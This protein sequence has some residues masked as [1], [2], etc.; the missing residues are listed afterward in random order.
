MVFEL[1]QGEVFLLG[2]SS[3]RAEKITHDRVLVTPAAG[4]PG[5]MPFWHGDRP[6][7]RASVRDAHRRAGARH[8][9]GTRGRRA[10]SADDHALAAGAPPK[11]SPPTC[12][13]RSRRRARCPS[14]RAIVVERFVD[15]I[16]DWRV[17]VL[18]PF[19]SRVI[20]P[21]AI[22]VAA[23]LREKY[24]DADVHY[25]DDGMAF[26]VPAC[27][28]PPPTELLL[29]SAD[30]IETH[31][32]ARPRGLGALRGALPRVRR[33]GRCSC[34][35]ATRDGAPRSGR[36]E[37]APRPCSRSRRATRTFPSSSRR[38]ASACATCSICRASSTLL[39][40]V[41]A[42]RVRVTTVDTRAPSPFAASVL[43]AFVANFIYE[44]D[45][46][47]AERRAQAMAIDF[48]R[49]R[50]LLGEAEIRQ[51]LDAER[52]RGARA[53]APAPLAA[54][55][56]RRRR[57]RHAPGRRRPLAR[58]APCA[59]L[60]VRPRPS[61][62]RGSSSRP[63]APCPSASAD[64][65][66]SSAA[67]DAA[68][69]RDAL[70]LDAARR[71]AAGA[72]RGRP[73]TR[74]AISWRATRARTDPSS[75][76]TSR[77]AS[78][79]IPAA[80]SAPIAELVAE[81]RLVEG[82]FLPGGTKRELCDR[83]VLE[84][85]RR[86]SL[87]KLRR[88][89]EPV[90]AR[91]LWRDSCS[92]GK[93]YRGRVA[94]AT[95]CSRS[96]ASSRAVPSWHRRW[97]PQ[98]C[99]RA[100]TR[101]A[102]GIS[103]RSARPAR[104]A[105]RASSRSARATGGSRSTART[106]RRCSIEPCA[107]VDGPL[108]AARARTARAP[109]GGV[110]RGDRARGRRIPRTRA[111][112]AV[113]DGVGRRGHQRHARAAAQSRASRRR[114]VVGAIAPAPSARPAHRA[115]REARAAGRF[116]RR[117]GPERPSDTDRRAALARAL[118]DR[119]GVVTREA[120]HAEGIAGGFAAVYDVLKALE[121]QGRVRRGYFVEGHGGAQF[122]LPGADERLRG[123]RSPDAA[124]PSVV[125]AASDPANAWG[126][127]LEW[128]SP[129][130]RRRPTPAVG[131]RAGRPSRRG[132]PRLARVDRGHALLTFDREPARPRA[133]SPGRSGPWSTLASAERCSS[134]PST[135][136]RPPAA[137]SPP[138]SSPQGSRRRLAGFSSVAPE[139]RPD[140]EL[141]LA[142]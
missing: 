62:G 119:Y 102:R 127:L 94:A 42:R 108:A 87:A 90:D 98:C 45:A 30:A 27:E 129:V 9:V 138:R 83:E 107:P 14:D 12:A 2:A 128:P 15:E 81:G 60:A 134:R 7:R 63:A 91:A 67:E 68:K 132:A 101:T 54:R 18:C 93:G 26:R 40:D 113:A 1:R 36:S 50:E 96:W 121:D 95:R 84:A 10:S 52:H 32:D 3:W 88:A 57:P 8:R 126:A 109:R 70:G 117:G 72:P 76:A 79:S 137:R 130:A 53:L 48:E 6:G 118:L 58:R 31:G 74:C 41:A 56:A 20:A 33:R 103:T 28:E 23:R 105:G 125:L 16:G 136:W 37:S 77:A 111:R 22:A 120:A 55:D 35:G 114:R 133:T 122:A 65:A 21:W 44:G 100:S 47:L 24:V 140:A 71:A 92:S 61:P 99:P 64:R 86:K 38:T 89:V 49:L 142:R 131:R 43:F 112:R 124:A 73:G 51:L 116:G 141:E 69:L 115:R 11:P 97:R 46:P 66:A 123:F 13:I 19:G 5:K 78:A 59:L 25:T 82:A 139:P 104:S 85:L 75:Q 110:L 29:P 17:V 39:R 4:Q 106:A 34:R 80:A 135:A